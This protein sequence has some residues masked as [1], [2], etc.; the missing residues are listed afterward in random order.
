MIPLYPQQLFQPNSQIVDQNGVGTKLFFYLIRALFNR[1]GGN[2]GLPFVVASNIAA[3]GKSQNT[4]TALSTDYSEVLTGSGGV[5]LA[6]LQPDQQQWVFNGSGAPI[7][8]YPPVNG[9]IDAI[10]VN[11]AYPLANG[12][13]QVF[14]CTSLLNSGGSF[15]RSFQPG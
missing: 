12:K 2:S 13:T 9:Q 6:G 7:N 15:L 3:A 1:S 10:A 5:V 4:A 8:V 11:D 14:T